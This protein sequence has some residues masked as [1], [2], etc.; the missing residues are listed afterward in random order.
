VEAQSNGHG[1]VLVGLGANC[2]G[3]WGTPAKTLQRALREIEQ[4]GITVK[5][6]S[7]LYETAA[8]GA[9]RQPPYVNQ[10]VLLATSLPA[11]ALLRLLKQIEM[12]AGRRGGRPWGQRT[13]DLDIID[14]KGL[15]MNWSRGTKGMPRERIRPLVLP[16]PQLEL[17]PFVLKPLLDIVP[18]WRHPVL[19]LSASTLWRR[20]RN[21]GQGSVLKRAP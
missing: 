12:G 9:V 16:H 17:R 11:P 13:L 2:P 20:L 14:Y 15:K 6:V 4:R 8:M 10:V 21:R 3:P 7:D 19:K 5:A 1:K 18:N